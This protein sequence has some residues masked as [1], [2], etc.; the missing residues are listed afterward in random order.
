VAD[1]PRPDAG[2]VDL[3]REVATALA[4]ADDLDQT[5]AALLSAAT[6]LTGADVGAVFL[7]DPDRVGMEPAVRAGIDEMAWAALAENLAA[8]GD[9]L[10]A[11]ARDRTPR[12]AGS[13]ADGG[14][15]AASTGSQRTSFEPLVVTRGGIPQG[16]GVL[17]VGWRGEQRGP[18]ADAAVA[19][20]AALAGVA[21]DHARLASLV[22][23]RSE[24][25]ERIAQS[26]PLTGL[27]NERA[28]ARILELELAR[29]ARQGSQV[30]LVLF[31]VDGFVAINEA[32]GN[33]AGDDVLKAVAAVLNESV[34]IVDTVARIGGD[35]FVVLAPGSAGST[36]ARRAIEGVAA[37]S[38]VAGRKVSISAGVARYPTSGAGAGEV[39][40]A[41]AAA[42]AEAKGRGPATLHEWSGQPTA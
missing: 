36:V 1:T 26:D 31:D 19:A 38:P 17:A 16:L 33:E 6:R 2:A 3:L 35:E 42:L 28:F 39:L 13:A 5:L 34:R 29:A 9:P 14:A 25:F 20:L 22:T 27:A 11:T 32:A 18:D 10:A 21:V 30:S 8:D 24:W 7:Q 23:E 15:F 37:L 40:D 4:G 12:R 41:A